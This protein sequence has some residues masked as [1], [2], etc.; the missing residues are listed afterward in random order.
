MPNRHAKKIVEDVLGVAR[1]RA[2]WTANYY[3]ALPFTPQSFD[4]GAVLP[5]MLY[6]ARFGHRRG[7]GRFAETFA[8][9]A[10]G[11]SRPPTIASV[12]RVLSAE[13]E[14]A[15]EGFDDEL[16][17]T[18]LGDLLLSW[19]LENK[20]HEEGQGLQV[21]RVLATHYF[22]SWVDL[23]DNIAN[24]RQIPELLTAILAAQSESEYV[25]PGLSA[26]FPMGVDSHDSSPLLDLFGRYCEIRGRYANDYASD[27]FDES[28]AH[29]IG[30]DELLAARIARAC[31][32]A[33]DKARGD[34]GIANRIPLATR[35]AARIR[36]DLAVFISMLGPLVPRQAF[37]QMLEA[38]MG[39]GILNLTLS[40]AKVLIDWEKT[41]RVARLAEQVPWPLFVDA[42]QGQD[43]TLREFSEASMSDCLTR[44]EQVPIILMLLR[45]LDDRVRNDRRLADQVPPSAPDSRDLLDLLGAIYRERHDR[46]EAVLDRIFEESRQLSKDLNAEYPDVANLLHE[47][48]PWKMAEGLCELMGRTL[49]MSKFL[50]VIDGALLTDKPNG[51]AVRRRVTRT[52]DGR[53]RTFDVRSVVLSSPALDFLVHRHLYA[54]PDTTEPRAL[55]LQQFLALL[56]DDYGLYVDREPPGQPIPSDLLRRNKDWLE[57]R[58]RDLGLLIGVNDAESMKQLR[59]RYQGAMAHAD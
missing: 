32:H 19:C 57:R 25:I 3:P 17:R 43:A 28:R 36:E 58:L 53:R 34:S 4:V 16:G 38:G 23:P 21:Q 22:S 18:M 29:D 55:S 44:F 35:A 15:I 49:Q 37:L 30:I 14:A 10:Q 40:T 5:A 26:S 48:S 1:T 2:L 20:K 9:D 6:M 45:L 54:S 7:K 27:H 51:L 56:R 12:A 47:G 41:G 24:L 33:P 42:S 8:D 50:Q 59:P 31:G 13:P 39:L 52:V 46:A 11:A